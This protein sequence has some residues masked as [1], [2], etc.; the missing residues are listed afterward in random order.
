MQRANPAKIEI[1]FEV[2]PGK[3]QLRCD[4]HTGKQ[5]GKA[6]EH[7]RNDPPAHDIIVVSLRS[8]GHFEYALRFGKRVERA[9]RCHHHDDKHKADDTHVNGKAGVLCTSYSRNNSE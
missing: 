3:G 2:Q 5:A 4:K 9:E 8:G 1:G 7:R 6:P